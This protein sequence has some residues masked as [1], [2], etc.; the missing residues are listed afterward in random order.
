MSSRRLQGWALIISAAIGLVGLLGGDSS[1]LRILLLV[2]ALLLML[3]VPAIASV[4][5]IGMLGWVGIILIELSALIALYLGFT[6]VTGSTLA[7]EALPF[8]SAL[9]GAIGRVIV[10]WLTVRGKAFPGWAGWSFI[11][12]GFLNFVGGAFAVALLSPIVAWIVPL[13]GAAALFAYGWG[14]VRHS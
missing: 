7:G 4:Q 5:P 2:G 12:E 6:S 14:V 1:F 3:G 10:G 13:A 9:V 11:L 8:A